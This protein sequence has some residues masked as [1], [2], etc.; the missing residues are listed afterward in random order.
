[1][2]SVDDA[3]ARILEIVQPLAPHPLALDE[4]LRRTLAEDVVSDVDVPPFDKSMMDGFAVNAA[5]TANGRTGLKVVEEILAGSTPQRS[6]QSGEAAQIMTGAP[7]PS[8][9]DAVIPVEQTQ[10]DTQRGE[11][12]LNVRLV[13]SGLNIMPRAAVTRKGETVLSAGRVIR[14]QEVAALA[15]WGRSPVAVFPV[16]RVAVLATGNEL[17]PVEQ[18]PGPGQIRNSNESMLVAQIHQIGAEPVPLGIARDEESELTDR[19][20]HGLQYDVLLLSGGVSAGK[21]DLVPAALSRCGIREVFHKVRVKPGKPI[22]FGH[23]EETGCF[24]FGLP[25]NPVSSMVC[26]DLFVQTAL[27]RLLGVDPARKPLLQAALEQGH[28]SHGDRSVYFPATI[29]VDAGQ[30]SARLVNWQGS[31]DLRSVT[32]ANGVVFIPAGDVELQ[33]GD[34]VDVLIWNL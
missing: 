5:D 15:E 28:N 27:R 13:S 11:V 29:R 23:S 33:A 24:V 19:I 12:I 2:L 3:F 17:V 18:K 20:E 16:P 34:K 4:A 26:F 30:L 32:D 14:P 1:M 8:G 31:S 25:G 22:W 10:Y 9:A 21:R 6:I 7:I